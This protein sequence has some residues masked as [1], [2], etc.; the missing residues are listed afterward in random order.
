MIGIA[1]GFRIA[2]PAM[3]WDSGTLYL[4]SV[5]L[6]AWNNDNRIRIL[7]EIVFP[8]LLECGRKKF[9]ES[10]HRINPGVG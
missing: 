2:S 7:G 4:V 3:H 10:V 8:A 1:D 5:W 6:A 9:D